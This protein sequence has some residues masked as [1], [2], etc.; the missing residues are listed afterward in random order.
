MLGAGGVLVG[1]GKDTNGSGGKF[2]PLALWRRNVL[3]TTVGYNCV[4][5]NVKEC[6]RHQR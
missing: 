4:R 2:T 5:W 3:V 6:Y 1:I